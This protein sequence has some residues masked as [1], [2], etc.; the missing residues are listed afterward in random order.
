MFSP[1]RNIENP[2][3]TKLTWNAGNVERFEFE[4]VGLVRADY[5]VGSFSSLSKD[6]YAVCGSSSR[7]ARREMKAST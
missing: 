7:F 6:R 5:P 4:K 1:K 3:P 2:T